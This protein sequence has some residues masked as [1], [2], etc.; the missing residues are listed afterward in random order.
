[1]AR[2][3]IVG[4]GIGDM[5]RQVLNHHSTFTVDTVKP[6]S[7]NDVDEAPNDFTVGIVCTPNFTHR[8]I[9]EKLA[10]KC[11]IVLIEKPGLKSQDEWRVLVAKYPNT[12]FMMIKNNMFR[13]NIEQIKSLVE[14][15]DKIDINWINKNRVPK[16]GSWFTNKELAFGGVSRDL[17]PHLLSLYIAMFPHHYKYNFIWDKK[18][19]QNWKLEDLTSSEYGNVDTSGIYN[20]DDHVYINTSVR[21]KN[22]LLTAD[23]KSDSEDDIAIHYHIRSDKVNG[24]I[25]IPLGLCPES[26]YLNM[27]ETAIANIDNDLFWQLQYEYDMFIHKIIESL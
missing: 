11:R 7:F 1:M 23:W 9:A 4:L 10:E 5:Y 16:P 26:A 21:N 19:N 18:V 25:I 24:E 3:L 12:R 14:N 15:A 20:V 27:V 8:E 22:V 2:I 17:I 6:A 13:D